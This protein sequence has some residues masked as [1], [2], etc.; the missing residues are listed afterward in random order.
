MAQMSD[1]FSV[2]NKREKRGGGTGRRA[3]PSLDIAF[4][5]LSAT[6]YLDVRGHLDDADTELVE[7]DEN[8][9]H[10]RTV[11][12]TNADHPPPDGDTGISALR[13][14][15]LSNLVAGGSTDSIGVRYHV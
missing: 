9:D 2:P 4:H 14:G 12:L 10:V 11:D 7:M 6:R 13:Y 15:Q 8:I 5:Q 3:S 1:V